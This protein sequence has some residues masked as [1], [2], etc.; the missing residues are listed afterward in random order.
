MKNLS[1][2]SFF[3][4]SGALTAALAATPGL[5]AANSDPDRPNIILCMSDD[6]G[7]GDVGYNG[8]PVLKTPNL[9]RMSKQGLRFDRFYAG[10]PVCSPTRASCL[11]GRH[12]YRQGIPWANE[13]HLRDAE[14]NL[15]EVLKHEGYATGHF[16]KWHLGTLTKETVD[17]RRGGR[18][19]WL[20]HYAP[21]WEHGFDEC[22]STESACPTYWREGYY[23]KYGVRY[24]TGPEE[25]VPE[26]ELRGDDSRIVMDHAL[27][28]I[29]SS[30]RN[31]KPFLAGV[32]FHAPHTPVLSDSPDTDGYDE[33]ENYYGCISAMDEQMGRLRAELERL[34]A[35]DNTMLW[36]CSDNGPIPPGR[37]GDLKGRKKSLHEGG[38]RVPGLLVWPEKIRKNR[39]VDM[40][41]STSDYFPTILEVLGIPLP[42]PDRPYDGISLLPLLEGRMSRRPQPIGFESQ[43]QTAL[44][45]E[46]YKIYSRNKGKRYEM[47]DLV[48]DPGENTDISEQHPELFQSMIKTLEQWRESC[49]QSW[50]G[51]DY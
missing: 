19:R 47:Y 4:Y 1:R 14:I 20:N 37:K 36:F 44:I 15:A 51:A 38:V 29:D 32:W 13:G 48:E 25:L 3:C 8:H 11:T 50:K 33:H 34:G 5:C 45:D 22:F 10:A 21:P 27:E 26:S 6:H 18:E 9:D 17:A 30:V 24:W 35:A 40:P 16:G 41:C 2:R 49:R 31:D 43:R 39:V 28:F 12:P 7:W 46:R 23:D 42:D